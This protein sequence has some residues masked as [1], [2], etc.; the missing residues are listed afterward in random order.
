MCYGSII[1]QYALSKSF[2]SMLWEHRSSM[3]Y[4]WHMWE[5]KYLSLCYQ[6]HMWEQE[7]GI[8]KLAGALHKSQE[9]IPWY[10]WKSS[11]DQGLY[12]EI[13]SEMN[14]EFVYFGW[15]T[16]LRWNYTSFLPP[17]KGFM[18]ES[19]SFHHKVMQLK[20]KLVQCFPSAWYR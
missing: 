6:C 3:C 13:L 12:P 9:N 20:T 7:V 4:G 1:P 11:R 19:D 18:V 14:D 10:H 17:K 16:H 8:L 5:M 15:R 2:L